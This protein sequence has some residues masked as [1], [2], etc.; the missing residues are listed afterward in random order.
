M[1]VPLNIIIFSFR[2]R[3]LPRWAL[4]PLGS[5]T[6]RLA[7][8]VALRPLPTL[9]WSSA[10]WDNSVSMHSAPD[11]RSDTLPGPHDSMR[12]FEGKMLPEA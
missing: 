11:R 3:A 4:I 2:V 5:Q 6:I 8:R 12:M 10:I 1:N 7:K 9:P